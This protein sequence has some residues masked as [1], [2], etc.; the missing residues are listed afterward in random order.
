MST[1]AGQKRILI[2]GGTAQA[3]NI[4]RD[5][6]AKGNDVITALAG[7]TEAPTLPPGRH[8]IGG[9]GGAK[10]LARYLKE[11]GIDLLIDAT[12]PFAKTISENAVLAAQ[13]SGIPLKTVTRAPWQAEQGETWL[14]VADE[15]AAAALL[16]AGARAFLALGRQHVALFRSRED[17]HFILRV[18]DPPI[19][20]ST[21]SRWQWV[22]GKPAQAADT[23]KAL[24]EAHGITHLVCRNSGGTAGYAKLEAA[25]MLSLPVV[26]IER[27]LSNS[28]RSGTASVSDNAAKSKR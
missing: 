2:L 6:I 28:S 11:E 3:L 9:F 22:I 25:R 12:H 17:C 13:Q 14:K 1:D 24:F 27:P 19:E 18:V 21:D 7:R 8:R 26:M 15:A 10:G 5:E 4:A 16:P 20:P 23:E